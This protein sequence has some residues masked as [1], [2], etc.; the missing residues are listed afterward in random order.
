MRSAT[1]YVL[2]GASVL[3]GPYLGVRAS[4]GQ[5]V[6]G[7]V[8]DSSGAAISDATVTLATAHHA[9]IKTTKSDAQGGFTFSDVP[10]GRYI[11]IVSSRGFD[12]RRHAL[13]VRSDPIDNLELIIGPRPFNEEVTVTANPGVVETVERIS[14][15][16]NIIGEQQIEER[17]ASVT[18]EVANEE[19]GVHLQRTSPTI[20]GIFV[21][22]LTGN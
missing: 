15:Q 3:A 18:A 9:V 5:S 8:R 16:V 21:R 12:D 4:D 6:S 22:G 19:V 17:A 10:R 11:V 2:V 7:V 14:Q 13:I 1:C 20:A